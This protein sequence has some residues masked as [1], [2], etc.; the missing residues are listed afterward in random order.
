[1]KRQKKYLTREMILK[2]ID[3]AQKKRDMARK[4]AASFADAAKSWAAFNTAASDEKAAEAKEQSERW[5]GIAERVENTRLVK[6]KRTLAA[7][8]TQPMFGDEQTV[9]QGK[10]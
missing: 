3:R 5:W 1:M 8:D 9:L 2:D 7:F 10:T 6:L 4:T